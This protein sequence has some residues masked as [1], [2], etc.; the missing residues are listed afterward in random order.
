MTGAN[1]LHLALVA[2][3]SFAVVAVAGQFSIPLLRR[4]RV[5]QRVRDDGPRTHLHKEGTPTMGGLFFVLPGLG[6]AVAAA[7][8]DGAV[9]GA[10]LFA[11]VFAGVGFLD[12]YIKVVRRRPL[13]LRAR[14]K[15]AVQIP[16]ALALALYATRVLNLGSGLRLP[17]GGPLIE[18]G[19]MYPLAVAFIAVAWGNAVN[20]T[21]GLDGLVAGAMLPSLGAYLLIALAVG[22]DGLGLLCAALIGACLGFLIYNHY[23]ARVIMGDVGALGLGGAFVAV[24]VLTKTEILLALVGGLYAIEALSVTMQ[25]ISFRTTGRRIFR[26]S[27]LHHHFELLGWPETRVLKWFWGVSWLSGVLGLLGLAGMGG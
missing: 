19:P 10:A 12:D 4:L 15:L 1:G 25:V 17:F 21:D 6:I 18:L 7:R 27:P 20:V 24:A 5:G 3:C 13:G 2:A 22:Q 26:M 16:A 14:H 23:P 11:L 8:G 9:L